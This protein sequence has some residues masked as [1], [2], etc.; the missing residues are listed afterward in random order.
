MASLS[1]TLA[2][3]IPSSPEFS[4]TATKR[5][6]KTHAKRTHRFQVS[7]N[8]NEKPP[9]TNP[10]PEKLILPPETSL[11]RQNVDRRN[12]LLGLGGLYT[13]TNLN[14]LPP[15]F[16][17]PIKAP[18]FVP[19]CT[20][21]LWNLDFES[22]VRTGA[23][24]PPAAKELEMDY[25][26]PTTGETRIRQPVHRASPE[27][28]QKFKD[29]MQK[30]KALPDDDPCSFKNQAKVHCAYCNNSYTQMA[31][32]YPEK[33]LQVHYSWLFFPFHRW[34]LYFF[35]R[36]LGDLIEDK[37]F[38]LPYWNWDNPAGMEIP[39]VFEDGGRSNPLYNSYRNVNHLRPAVIDLDYR[40]KE[41][42]ISPLDQVRINLCIMN[43]Q[44]KRNAS[45]PTSFF[46]GEY[47]AGDNPIS[48]VGSIEAGCHT[49]V[50]RWVGD[51]R[52]PNEEDLGNFYSAAYD[53]LFYVHHAN[54][55]RMW[56]LWKGL[57]GEG[58]KEPNDKNWEEASYVFYDENRKPVRV[59][60]KHCVNLEDLKY[61]Y[62][63]SETPWKS[64]PP[65]PRSATY[66]E[67]TSPENV[68]EMEFPLSISETVTVQVKRPETNRPKDQKKTIKE[69]LLLKGI[70]F[71]GGKFVKFDVFVNIFEDINRISPCESQ[72]AGGFGLLPHKTSEKM[73]SKTGVRIE[74]TELLEEINADG[75]D[76]VQVTIVPRV[77][78]DDVTFEDIKI[79]LIDVY[80]KESN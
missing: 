45:D 33:V 5:R 75:D 57:G 22:G 78:C 20:D 51:P 77:G 29:A 1:S 35:E 2:T 40:M 72:Y 30:M 70:N 8:D 43:R 59:Y 25:K 46:G 15:V 69:I 18:S 79:E 68:T 16:A 61:E 50:H 24:C 34:F 4:K 19:G 63:D 67:T 74:L 39:A 3:V 80:E 52:T 28:I 27:Y 6:L 62:E 53:P 9:T 31:S 65:K 76:S 64:N 36:I 44:M 23:C 56:T 37:T 12:L 11:N 47:V 54:V 73:N 17:N 7:C 66:S 26:F 38:G 14:T 21:S 60:N 42:N 13:T 58:R 41:R 10:Q 49:A 48:S 71:N 32:G 55:D